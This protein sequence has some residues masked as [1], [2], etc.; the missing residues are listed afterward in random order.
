MD[1]EVD[2]LVQAWGRE[3]PGLDLAPIEVFSRIDR[4][5]H[6]LDRARRAAFTAHGVESWEFDVLAALRR[7]GSPYQL[8]PGQLLKETLVTSGTMTNRVDRL[9]DRDFV[10]R[11]PDPHDR[12]GVL[13]RLLPAGRSTVDAA[14]EALLAAEADVLAAL[15]TRDRAVLAR[16]LRRL[17]TTFP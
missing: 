14:F 10:E 4:L 2:A 16:T 12:R 9:V 15:P 17:L 1:D 13:V 6:H 3:R 11:L 7:A 5:S 8:S